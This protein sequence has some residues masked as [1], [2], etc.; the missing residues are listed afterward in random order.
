[1]GNKGLTE[2]G[3][4]LL[5]YWRTLPRREGHGLP[6]W[7]DISVSSIALIMEKAWVLEHQPPH[8]MIVKYQGSSVVALA[9]RDTTG[10]D[11]LTARI[12]PEN[13]A[14]MMALYRLVYETRC[15]AQLT[16]L[17]SEA[18][19]NSK[20]MT[21]TFFP[22]HSDREGSWMLLGISEM[23]TTDMS[24]KT[25]GSADFFSSHLDQP[26]FVDLGFGLPA[27]EVTAEL[28]ALKPA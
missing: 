23:A 10:K 27:N 9:G 16:R 20:I 2:P 24:A 22:L 25:E 21:T 5:G 7:Q 26:H 11:F 1:M 19:K 13:R 17:I 8:A 18:G 28:Q 4:E 15:G 6:F 3:K 12:A 14:Y